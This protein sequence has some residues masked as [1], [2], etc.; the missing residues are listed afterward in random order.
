MSNLSHVAA[1]L[2]LSALVGCGDDTG[3]T[4]VCG[5]AIV[6]AP[7]VCDDGEDNGAPGRC[8][9]DCSGNPALVSVQGDVLAF[10]S[11]VQGERISG[12]K[13]S[14]L[15]HPEMTF[16]TQEDAHF[17]FDGLEE[18]SELTL[19]VEHPDFK[20]TQT[21]TLILGPNGVDPF[22]I[23]IVPK[24][25]FAA[26]SNLV[27]L[28]VEEDKYCVIATTAARMGGSL[29]VHLRQG[30]DGVEVSLDPP[31]PAESG[32]IYFNESVLPD[33]DQTATST[34]GG[35]LFYRVPPGAY[36]LSA[37]RA[38]TVF[39]TVR[40]QCRAGFIVNAGPPLGLLA[41][42]ESPDYGAGHARAADAYSDATDALCEATAG[43]VNAAADTVR[44][45]QATVE[46]C[47]AM[48]RNMWAYVD[49]SCDADS[50]IRASAK[51]LYECR[52]T[53]CDVTL[54]GDEACTAEE[55]AFR[56]AEIAY[57]RCLVDTQANL[58]D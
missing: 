7:E 1:V 57:G 3:A 26:M 46:S 39:N 15:E 6:D 30:A 10:M 25:L 37:T 33:L 5:D 31:V 29:Y 34:D 41:N 2:T 48:F 58:P 43:C 49:E 17:R 23:Q 9:S 28:P 12:A 54:G 32:P 40:F 56:A 22:S 53:S 47:K 36:V 21:A 11:E 8:K 18:G 13:V 42:V 51:A 19:V 20:T 50:A 45:P 16:V 38:D 14:V 24:S 35:V 4:P 55:E 27:P 44:Y 52:T